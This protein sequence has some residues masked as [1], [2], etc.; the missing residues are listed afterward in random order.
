M[1]G[2]QSNAGRVV[3]KPLN[4]EA[5][6]RCSESLE[7]EIKYNI[8]KEISCSRTPTATVT[9]EVEYPDGYG[10]QTLYEEVIS[11]PLTIHL[12]PQSSL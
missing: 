3:L 11:L 5:I 12:G 4:P 1:R 7:N 6:N 8:S 9:I 2:P 10:G